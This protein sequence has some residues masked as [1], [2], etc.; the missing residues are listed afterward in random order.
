LKRRKKFRNEFDNFEK[1]LHNLVSLLLKQQ[2]GESSEANQIKRQA[3]SL[4]VPFFNNET[5]DKCGRLMRIALSIEKSM[6]PTKSNAHIEVRNTG[7][8]NLSWFSLPL[9]K[10][11]RCPRIWFTGF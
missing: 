11:E 6:A 10:C 3:S 9:S 2:R 5:T 7:R 1:L 4:A 8:S